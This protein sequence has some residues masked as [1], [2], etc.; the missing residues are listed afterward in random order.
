[1]SADLAFATSGLSFSYEAAS[2]AGIFAAASSL[3]AYS[4]VR[5]ST[6][7]FFTNGSV[8]DIRPSISAR[9]TARSGMSNACAGRL[10]QSK[11]CIVIRGDPSSAAA[12]A[13]AFT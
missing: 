11:H 12:S 10:W 1:M 2:A 13:P 5:T 4:A 9:S 7:R 3:L 6:D 8:A